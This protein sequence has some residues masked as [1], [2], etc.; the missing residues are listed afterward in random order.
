MLIAKRFNHDV[1]VR[2]TAVQE[3]LGALSA[4]VQENLTGMAV[5]RAYTMEA[6][7]I[8]EFEPAQRGVP[9]AQPAPWR[10]SSRC[11]GR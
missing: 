1:E 2:S 10:A 6:R 5:V 11:P 7:E 9:D 8:A 4:K 3:Q